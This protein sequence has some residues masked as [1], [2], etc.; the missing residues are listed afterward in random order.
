MKRWIPIVALLIVASLVLT[1]CPAPTPQIIEVEKP[2]VVEKV[3]EKIVEVTPTLVPLPE[4][5]P[6]VVLKWTGGT[7]YE[8][9]DA[10]WVKPFEEETG[11]DVEYLEGGLLPAM[12]KAMVESGNVTIDLFGGDP[13]VGGKLAEVGLV[14]KIN[15]EWIEEDYPGLTAQIPEQWRTGA[16]FGY[17]TPGHVGCRVLAYR[18]DAFDTPPESWADFWDVEKFPGPRAMWWGGYGDPSIEMALFALGYTK[19][20]MKEITIE[21][22]DE[23]YAKLDEIKPYVVKWTTA[24]AESSDM[25][26]RGEIVMA[27][28]W[29]GRVM[30]VIEGGA[31]VAYTFNQARCAPGWLAIPSNAPHPRNAHKLL[32]YIISAESQGRFQSHFAYGGVNPYSKDFVAPERWAVLSTGYADLAVYPSEPFYNSPI[33]PDDIFG[34][35]WSQW[36]AE[37]WPAFEAAAPGK[38]IPS[39]HIK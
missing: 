12:L 24:G 35:S 14:Q 15:W 28:T 21:M 11:I 1:A 4:E 32:G 20:Q 8:A 33:N 26:A 3:V 36:L 34:Q 17:G 19:D 7:M 10:Y 37:T 2:V 38:W 27:D 9:I 39:E 5:E 6:K 16:I 22:L 18:T 23:A 13:W 31:P 25:L 30:A 29:D